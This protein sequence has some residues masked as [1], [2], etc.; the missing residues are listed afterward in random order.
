MTSRSIL[1]L[2]ALVVTAPAHA[3][4]QIRPDQAAFR[5]LYR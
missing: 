5:D 4:A 2:I 3:A 1:L